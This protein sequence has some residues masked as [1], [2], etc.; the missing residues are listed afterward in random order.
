MVMIDFFQSMALI[1]PYFFL[2]ISTL[3]YD[4]QLLSLKNLFLILQGSRLVL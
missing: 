4:L 3:A 2:S 1:D